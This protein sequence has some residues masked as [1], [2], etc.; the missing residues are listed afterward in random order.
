MSSTENIIGLE[1]EMNKMNLRDEWK[2]ELRYIFRL[3]IS[4][5]FVMIALKI[6]GV[7]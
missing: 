2:G 4:F 6:I 3:A 1:A 5:I 7:W